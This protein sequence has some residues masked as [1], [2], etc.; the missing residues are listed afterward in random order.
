MTLSFH[1][2][3]SGDASAEHTAGRDKSVSYNN[4]HISS[5]NIIIKSS[6]D[7][8][9]EG[10]IVRADNSLTLDIGND[11]I[12]SSV[13]DSSSNKSHTIGASASGS[14]SKSKV[15]SGSGGAN[16]SLT[17]G[18]SKWVEEQTSLT[19]G[20]TVN[21]NVAGS[22]AL[23]GSVIG[24]DT[25]DLTLSTGS[26]TYTDIKDKNRS[27]T[28]GAGIS[29]TKKDAS[30]K[31][32]E[33]AFTDARKNNNATIGN[34]SIIIRDN[35][36][37]DLSD[38]NRDLTLAS[39]DTKNTGVS[40]KLDKAALDA[41][42]NPIKTAK[43]IKD[44]SKQIG[45]LGLSAKDMI[46]AGIEKDGGILNTLKAVGLGFDV[47]NGVADVARSDSD[48]KKDLMNTEDLTA[49]ELEKVMSSMFNGLNE[50]VGIT[51]ANGVKLVSSDGI[52]NEKI[53]NF[54]AATDE[55]CRSQKLIQASIQK[56]KRIQK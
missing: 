22:T 36:D 34:G 41:M 31:N 18:K 9:I 51:D 15:A 13:Q 14:Y 12:I 24:S 49:D 21:I 2:G 45:Y 56:D 47:T 44:N 48:K 27:N 54:N 8:R 26:L 19:G 43:D 3:L 16:F 38:L 42:L 32:A 52:E 40:M 5:G 20:G 17:D 23:K 10:A 11:L 25:D 39:I 33:F 1:G 4:S 7:T 29:L 55:D 28:L 50:N 46:K 30:F 6:E 35:P 37:Q 53:K